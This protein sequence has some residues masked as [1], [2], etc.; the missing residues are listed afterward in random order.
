MTPVKHGQVRHVDL[1]HLALHV[2]GDVRVDG[3]QLAE[4]PQ[5]VGQ[6]AGVVH[7]GVGDEDG[8]GVLLGD[9]SQVGGVSGVLAGVNKVNLSAGLNGH[10]G[11]M[12]AGIGF[13]AGAASQNSDFQGSHPFRI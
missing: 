13:G 11:L 5:K 12:A 7:V 4:I 9:T 10:G 1:N 8:G 6:A 3:A 2:G